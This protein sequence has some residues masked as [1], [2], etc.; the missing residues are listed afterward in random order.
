M[1][2]TLNILS[3]VKT[4]DK[5]TLDAHAADCNIKFVKDFQ[6][7]LQIENKEEILK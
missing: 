4:L 2:E 6:I 7:R 5:V 1:L 3:I